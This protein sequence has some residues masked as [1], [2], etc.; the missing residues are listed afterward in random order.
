MKL[1]VSVAVS[2]CAG[3]NVVVAKLDRDGPVTAAA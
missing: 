3:D 2:D 1:T